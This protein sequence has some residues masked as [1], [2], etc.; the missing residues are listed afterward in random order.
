MDRGAS[1]MCWRGREGQ[2]RCALAR[3]SCAYRTVLCGCRQRA[4]LACQR[5]QV[6]A[7]LGPCNNSKAEQ[8]KNRKAQQTLGK[9]HGHAQ[10]RE[11]AA[12][13]GQV[14]SLQNF[15]KGDGRKCVRLHS[16]KRLPSFGCFSRESDS[17]CSTKPARSALEA[18]EYRGFGGKGPG[19]LQTLQGLQV[20][21]RAP[22][23]FAA[24]LLKPKGN[25]LQYH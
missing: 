21:R 9:S 18:L 24:S 6:N 25:Q 15:E 23:T 4:Y 20:S 5:H 10:H 11:V 8:L 16:R 12:G 17:D 3:S 1:R 22:K 7:L 14:V 19:A 13:T 2:G